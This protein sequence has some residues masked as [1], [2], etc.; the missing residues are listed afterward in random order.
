MP[1][2]PLAAAFVAVE[3]NIEL[4]RG[5]TGPIG[6]A[7]RD[8]I[9]GVDG[10]PGPEGPPGLKG[11]QGPP[12]FTPADIDTLTQRWEELKAVVLRPRKRSV[13]RDTQGRITGLTEG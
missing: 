1:L 2:D 3:E 10:A 12:G 7:G 9:D 4:L 11:P 8:G 6:R 5:K 13:V